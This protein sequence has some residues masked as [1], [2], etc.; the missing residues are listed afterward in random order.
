MKHSTKFITKR[1]VGLILFIPMVALGMHAGLKLETSLVAAL[2]L[3]VLANRY[4]LWPSV[5][6]LQPKAP[7]ELK[8]L[9]RG[10]YLV[11]AILAGSLAILLLVDK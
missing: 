7:E 10:Y 4:L 11:F 3:I 9:I 5:L 8:W 2:L 1:L 6:T